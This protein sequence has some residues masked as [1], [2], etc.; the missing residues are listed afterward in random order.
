VRAARRRSAAARTLLLTAVAATALAGCQLVTSEDDAAAP[1]R[2]PTNGEQQ[3]E[4]GSR[5]EP[6]AMPPAPAG[7]VRFYGQRV[8]WTSCEGEFECGTVEV[9]LDYDDPR[10]R[11]IEIAVNRRQAADADNR[12]GAL[13]VNPGGPGVPGT[14]YARQLEP[15][16]GPVRQQF[17]VVGFDPRGVGDSTAV[18]CVSDAELDSYL[19]ADGSPDTRAE[20][21]ALARELEAFGEGCRERSGEL[22]EHVSTVE[23]ARDLDVIRQAVGDPTM[24]YLGTSYGTLLGATYAELFPGRVSRMVLDA[25]VDPTVT[26]LDLGLAQL[27]GFETALQAYLTDCVES[28]SCPLGDTVAAAEQRLIE[29]L[30]EI[31]AEPLSTGGDRRLTT[32]WAFYGLA[33]PL[34][35][36]ELWPALTEALS[37]ALEGDGSGLLRLA[38]AYASRGSDGYANNSMEAFVAINCA[39]DPTA[40]TPAEIRAALPRF[41]A[42]S[43]VFGEPFAWT[44]LGCPRWPVDGGQRLPEI[45]AAGAEPILVVGTTRDP[46]TPYEWA[47]ALA[48][49]LDSGVLLTRD[50]D[51]HG[52]YGHGNAC[53]DEAVQGYLLRGT[54]PRAGTRC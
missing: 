3:T 24:H 31:D 2:P 53:L 28:G 16:L 37:A 34:Y 45:D 8:Q 7:L 30:R 54:V 4:P 47:E 51:G 23:A 5:P 50:G 27:R 19:A 48:E 43:E 6:D 46:A 18:D 40:R 14:G 44:S 22:V 35:A 32:G 25:A 10:G 1:D 42:V 41:E 49:Q 15:M 39:D 17:D 36:A 26:G 20:E 38:D 33:L 9:P 29:L 12:Q 52:A 13:L 21:Q 11:T